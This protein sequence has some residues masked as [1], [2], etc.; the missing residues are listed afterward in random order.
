MVDNQ[1]GEVLCYLGSADFSN[2]DFGGQVDGVRAVRSPGSTLKPFLYGMSFDRGLATANTTVLDVPT[3]YGTYQPE[4]YDQKFNGKVSVR[5][6][7][8]RSLNVPAVRLLDK[9]GV[10]PF[11]E[12]LEQAGLRQ[13]GKDKSNLGL[14]VI[15]EKRD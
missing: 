11:I 14:S 1:T 6:A 4:N 5:E 2:T 12:K 7:L 10:Y 15:V 3:D 8:A 13:V 9:L